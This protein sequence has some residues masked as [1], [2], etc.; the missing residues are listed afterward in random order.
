VRGVVQRVSRASVEVDGK[1]VSA[2]GP[3]LLLFVG[4][5]VGDG[6]ADA[7]WLAEKV[8]G[9]RVFRDAEGL[10][11]LSLAETGG[12]VLAVS[13]FT[14]LGD[15]RKGRRPSWSAAEAPEPAR[16]LYARVCELLRA[17]GIPVAEGVF[18]ADMAVSSVNEGPVTML[19]DSK[20][21]F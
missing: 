13:Q 17:R 6:E 16:L 4:V 1:E 11:N 20:K 10:M 7:A 8:A 21:L 18:Q 12:S 19:L 5:A 3:G 9:L 14:L 2:I 15:A